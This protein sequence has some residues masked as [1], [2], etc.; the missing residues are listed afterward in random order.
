MAI[1]NGFT[2]QKWWFSIAMLIYQKVLGGLE[3]HFFGPPRHIKISGWNLLDLKEDQKMISAYKS[4]CLTLLSLL[5]QVSFH[6]VSCSKESIIQT[7]CIMYVYMNVPL[8]FFMFRK[9]FIDQTHV[10]KRGL[11]QARLKPY[12]ASRRRHLSTWCV[13][14]KWGIARGYL[15]ALAL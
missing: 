6:Y 4:A 8:C 12:R 15:L 10:L 2:H 3:S 11:C 14:L 13:L 9:Y 1:Y 7:L 5:K